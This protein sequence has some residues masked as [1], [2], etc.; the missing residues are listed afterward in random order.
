MD[1]WLA[2]FLLRAWDPGLR[3]VSFLLGD[4]R[5]SGGRN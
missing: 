3:R 2:E 1:A 4:N 5:S